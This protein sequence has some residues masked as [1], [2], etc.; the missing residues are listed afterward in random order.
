MEIEKD[1]TQDIS[2]SID[3]STEA[4]SHDKA[5]EVNEENKEQALSDHENNIQSDDESPVIPRCSEHT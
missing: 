2:R 4:E 1:Y 5:K 3:V